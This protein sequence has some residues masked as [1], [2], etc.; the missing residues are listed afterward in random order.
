MKFKLLIGVMA[1]VFIT[2]DAVKTTTL[3]QNSNKS[4]YD[5]FHEIIKFQPGL[6]HDMDN[7]VLIEASRKQFYALKRDASSFTHQI[8]G[9]LREKKTV[10][11]RNLEYRHD[12]W[13]EEQVRFKLPYKCFWYRLGFDH[14]YLV[15]FI[16]ILALVG[17]LLSP[18]YVAYK[19][20]VFKYEYD[21]V[22]ARA[23]KIE[24]KRLE[25]SK[26]KQDKAEDQNLIEN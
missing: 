26:Q 3:Q 14:E 2:I 19:I 20:W 18:F 13:N 11:I 23:Q 15:L 17:C 1:S 9:L 6:C 25:Q 10:I 16:F 7:F 8:Q 5:K 21:F 24:K 22:K 12:Y 4:R